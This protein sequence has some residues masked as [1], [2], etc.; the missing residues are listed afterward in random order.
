VF[1]YPQTGFSLG[2]IIGIFNL[3]DG[4]REISR[5]VTTNTVCTYCRYSSDLDCCSGDHLRTVIR[6]MQDDLLPNHSAALV[7]A[8][9]FVS[10]SGV[11]LLDAYLFSAI[12]RTVE[13]RRP[14]HYRFPLVFA[15]GHLLSNCDNRAQNSIVLFFLFVEEQLWHGQ[16]STN[17]Q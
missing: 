16:K 4:R 2:I 6:V 9:A 13:Q 7:T 3:M 14:S 1:R 12:P 10:E 5:D 8:K 11:V 17:L 15:L